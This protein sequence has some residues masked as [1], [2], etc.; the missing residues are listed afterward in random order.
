MRGNGTFEPW[1]IL[2]HK[3][4]LSVSFSSSKYGSG[5]PSCLGKRSRAALSFLCP[6]VTGTKQAWQPALCDTGPAGKHGVAL[7]GE[8]Q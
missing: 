1:Y 7:P 4:S 2:L 6:Q 5:Q 8:G 3:R